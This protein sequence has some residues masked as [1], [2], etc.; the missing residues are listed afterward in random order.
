MY[1]LSNF[2]FDYTKK[3][4]EGFTNINN[5]IRFIIIMATY[6]R[7]NGKT[8]EYLD[9]S[10]N[11]I[12]NQNYNNWDLIVIGDKYEPFNELENIINT[13][14]QK[15]KNKIILLDNQNVERDYIKNKKNLW[16]SAGGTS[17]NLGLKYARENNYKYYC[18]LD[19]D[20]FWTNEHLSSLLEAY[21]YENCIFANTKSTY[22]GSYLPIEDMDIYE[23]NRIPSE[24]EVIHS[25]YSFRIDLIPF[26]YE[27]ALND[28]GID[29]PSD[30]IM[31]NKIKNF[32]NTNT[33]YKAIYVSKLT[34]F[35]DF[36][37]ESIK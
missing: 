12:I 14:Q 1:K 28:T 26:I 16:Y 25:S 36:E 7:T 35:H 30:Y 6:N 11:S 22:L 34:C 20:D 5:D 29:L 9:R 27:T 17:I 15:T 18:H 8:A 24:G 2:C 32:I 13:F 19:D 37:E 3:K 31:L 4:N 23:N 33:N 10:L 21:K